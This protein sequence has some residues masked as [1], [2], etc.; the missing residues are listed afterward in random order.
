MELLIKGRSF[1]AICRLYLIISWR[2]S[3]C[4][5][6]EKLAQKITGDGL[7]WSSRIFFADNLRKMSKGHPVAIRSHKELGLIV[8]KA[9]DSKS[10]LLSKGG[11]RWFG[12]VE[13]SDAPHAAQF[14]WITCHFRG[15]VSRS[16]KSY[17][18][19]KKSCLAATK[20]SFTFYE[21]IGSF[22]EEDAFV[23]FLH[24]KV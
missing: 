5:T 9:R 12:R 24:K 22:E 17:D 4:R 7:W 19:V 10:F 15:V 11:I 1:R 3:W 21:R 2:S 20:Y 13:S 14:E 16:D 23:G 6:S 8:R 18:I